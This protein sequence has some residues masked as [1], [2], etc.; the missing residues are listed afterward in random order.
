[1]R[2]EKRNRLQSDI[3]DPTFK[4]CIPGR[5]ITRISDIRDPTLKKRNRETTTV[6]STISSLKCLQESEDSLEPHLRNTTVTLQIKNKK[7]DWV[8]FLDYFAN[9]YQFDVFVNLFDIDIHRYEYAQI[10]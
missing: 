7:F 10:F 3:R 1:M 9:T 6:V 2:N 4:I 5:I 8:L